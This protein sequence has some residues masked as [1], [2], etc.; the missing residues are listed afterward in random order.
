MNDQHFLS[1]VLMRLFN[2]ARWYSSGQAS[3]MRP[4]P[5][6]PTCWRS[7]RRWTRGGVTSFPICLSP[8]A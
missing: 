8:A 6:A 1:A 4:P 5:A 7:R 3:G 2:A